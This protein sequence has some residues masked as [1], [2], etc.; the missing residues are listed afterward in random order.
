MVSMIYF[1]PLWFQA[2]KGVNPLNSGIDNLPMVLSLVVATIIAGAIITKTGFYNPWM[3]GCSV[4]MSVGAGL[5][6]TFKTD[7]GS[8]KWIGYQ[9]IFGFGIGMGMQQPGMAAQAVLSKKD[10]STGVSIMFFSQ[11]LGGAL[12]TCIGQTVFSNN[13]TRSLSK[14]AG[15]DASSILKAGATGL[16]DIVAGDQLPVVLSNYNSALS[17]AFIV[18]LAAAC[19]SF[20]PAIGVEWKNVKGLKHGGPSP[21]KAVRT[22][23]D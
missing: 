10:V 18:T 3:F 22:Q 5:M 19:F 20:I 7:T 14:I 15:I 11:S 16:R 21:E 6:T 12:F 8:T 13:L 1:L 9:F 4:F 2:I 23:Q 17:K